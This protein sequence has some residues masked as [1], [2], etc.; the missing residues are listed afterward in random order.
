MNVKFVRY[1]IQNVPVLFKI[2]KNGREY[3]FFIKSDSGYYVILPKI[4]PR[5]Y[6]AFFSI[7]FPSADER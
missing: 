6:G 1:F 7:N 5:E 3:F 4:P 2:L